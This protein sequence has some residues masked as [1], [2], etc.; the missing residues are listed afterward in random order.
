MDLFSGHGITETRITN[1]LS[2]V[3]GYSSTTVGNDLSGSRIVGSHFDAA[4]GEPIPTLGQRDHAFIDLAGFAEVK[5]HVVNANLFWMPLADFTLLTGF[6][7]T[8]ENRNS[9]STFLALEPEPNTPPFT[10]TN[11]EG[12]FHFGPGEPAGGA[13]MSDYDRFAERLEL[14]YTGIANWL[15]YAQGEWEEESGQSE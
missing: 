11:P 12:G 3:T 6:R 5:Q 1:S 14:R 15:F 10:P 4:F 13:R 7:Y 8:H 2:F 9:D